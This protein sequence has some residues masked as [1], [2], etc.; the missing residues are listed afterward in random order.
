ME[1]KVEEKRPVQHVE[2]VRWVKRVASRRKPAVLDMAVNS[3][4]SAAPRRLNGAVMGHK[5]G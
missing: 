5:E 2:R 4:R 1:R 3:R